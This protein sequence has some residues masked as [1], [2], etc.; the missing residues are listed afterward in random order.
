MSCVHDL[1]SELLET[2]WFL[3]KCEHLHV[4]GRLHLEICQ[5][6]IAEQVWSWSALVD[7]SI[8]NFCMRIEDV[9]R[10]TGGEGVPALLPLRVLT[11]E[12]PS[13]ASG[14]WFPLQGTLVVC[15]RRV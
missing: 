11:G 6:F 1:Q 13:L 7:V 12:D 10:E 9:S 4:R 2:D 15:V 5:A 3:V 14:K 8:V